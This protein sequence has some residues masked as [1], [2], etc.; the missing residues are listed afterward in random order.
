MT[1]PK[2]LTADEKTR[3]S[4]LAA[5]LQLMY[6]GRP[7]CHILAQKPKNVYDDKRWLRH[8]AF[9]EKLGEN[10]KDGGIDP[11]GKL[12][13]TIMTRVVASCQKGP[14]ARWDLLEPCVAAIHYLLDH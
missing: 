13:L 9:L 6:M 7:N 11:D 2:K 10:L 4:L 14:E 5:S 12:W 1:A 3:V 8:C